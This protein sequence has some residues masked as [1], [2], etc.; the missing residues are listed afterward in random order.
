MASA[1]GEINGGDFCGGL[2]VCSAV[3][4]V[5]PLAWEYAAVGGVCGVSAWRQVH[6]VAALACSC[7][8][9]ALVFGPVYPVSG[10]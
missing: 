10:E 7:L 5:T 4:G 8:A 3:C 1:K 9:L 6:V 2:L